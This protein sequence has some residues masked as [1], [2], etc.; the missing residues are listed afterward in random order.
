MWRGVLL[1]GTILV[2]RATG[3]SLLGIS[4]PSLLDVVQLAAEGLPDTSIDILNGM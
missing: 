2:S 1:V 3:K 4:Q